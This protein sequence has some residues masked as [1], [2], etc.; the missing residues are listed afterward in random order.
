MEPMSKPNQQ[1]EAKRRLK[2]KI[3]TIQ[4]MLDAAIKDLT[5]AAYEEKC[6]VEDYID[7]LGDYP[8]RLADGIADATRQASNRIGRAMTIV[9]EWGPALPGVRVASPGE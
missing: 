1:L 6:F 2:A 8:N 4:A 5:D 3:A 7:D 9:D